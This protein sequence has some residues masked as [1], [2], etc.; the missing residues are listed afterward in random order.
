MAVA[1]VS[2]PGGGDQ[3][4]VGDELAAGE[5]PAGAGL[6]LELVLDELGHDVVGGVLLS[7]VEVVV[8]P[9]RRVQD[10]LQH[11]LLG[12]GGALVRAGL[13]HRQQVGLVLAGNA[14]EHANHLHGQAQGEVL[15]EVESV[16]P[17]EVVDDLLA[18]PPDLGL[19]AGHGP[20]GEQPGDDGPVHRVLRLVL[21]DEEPR[22]H[23][24]A[25]AEDVEDVALAGGVRVPIAEDPGQVVVA[26]DRVEVVLLVVV[27]RRLAPQPPERLVRGRVDVP[28]VHVVVDVG[29]RHGHDELPL[30]ALIRPPSGQDRRLPVPRQA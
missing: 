25:L 29:C 16:P 27:E 30:A 6:V 8:E 24:D 15:H 19:E 23:V 14:D 13:E 21:G 2:L 10:A 18:D 4:E 20:G 26:A 11:L 7:P 5:L 3:R 9:R 22:R 12:I 28:V 1:V 17:F